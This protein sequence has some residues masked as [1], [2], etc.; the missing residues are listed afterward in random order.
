[1]P[2]YD[3]YAELALDKDMP[4][5]EIGQL[6][7]ERIDAL[8]GQGYQQNSPEVDQLATAQAILSDPVK[9]DAYET[10]LA[11]P[12]D[13]VDVP[14]LHSLADTATTPVGAAD[15]V[16]ASFFSG[17]VGGMAPGAVP[18]VGSGPM[19]G[20]AQAPVQPPARPQFDAA[21]LSVA[22]RGRSQSKAYLTCLVIM[23]LG[24]LYP[25]VVM[26]TAGADDVDAVY[27]ILKATMFAVAHTVAWIGIAEVIWAFRRIAA[28][29]DN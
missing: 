6:L 7:Q 26:F 3:L 16:A 23:V 29:E 10:A 11:G 13:V 25:L 24:M 22:G 18:G 20:T 15:P 19:P 8:L 17:P 14:W 21:S 9:R 28:P 2:N 27:H 4:P 1:M 12:D 5:T